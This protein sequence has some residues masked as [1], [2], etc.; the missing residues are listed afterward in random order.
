[1]A[2]LVHAKPVHAKPVHAKPVHE[3][4]VHEKSA[5]VTMHSRCAVERI[6]ALHCMACCLAYKPIADNSQPCSRSISRCKRDVIESLLQRVHGRSL[7]EH[8]QL[9]ELPKRPHCGVLDS[10]LFPTARSSASLALTA[11]CLGAWEPSFLPHQGQDQKS[12]FRYQR[13]PD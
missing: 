2:C 7:T 12:I 3:K 1:M 4:L 5:S 10:S 8:L 13:H 11:R 6:H 9:C